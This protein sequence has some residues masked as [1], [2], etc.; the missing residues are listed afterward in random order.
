MKN[1]NINDLK[2]MVTRTNWFGIKLS[3]MDIEKIGFYY[4]G[5]FALYGDGGGGGALPNLPDLAKLLV[6]HLAARTGLEMKTEDS[7]SE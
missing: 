3:D 5:S 4:F 6:T 7:R 1:N 2:K